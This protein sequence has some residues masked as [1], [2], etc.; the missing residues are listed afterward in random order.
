MLRVS[1]DSGHPVISVAPPLVA[2]EVEFALLT[3][4]LRYVLTVVDRN[5]AVGKK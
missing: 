1:L 5:R 2:G 4:A 3:D